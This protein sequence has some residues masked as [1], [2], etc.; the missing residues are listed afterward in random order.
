MPRSELLIGGDGGWGNTGHGETRRDKQQVNV[1]NRY[2][3]THVRRG[4]TRNEQ[5][6]RRRGTR[7]QGR[8][9]TTDG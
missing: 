4:Q 7:T 5:I 6:N 3:R 2:N 8:D 1:M 9:R